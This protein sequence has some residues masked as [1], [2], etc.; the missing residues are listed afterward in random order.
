MTK[1]D[2]IAAAVLAA[3]H[4]DRWRWFRGLRLLA[5]VVA[6]TIA[7][8]PAVHDLVHWITGG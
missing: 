5:V 1:A 2:E 6:G 7:G 8:V 3:Q 4:A